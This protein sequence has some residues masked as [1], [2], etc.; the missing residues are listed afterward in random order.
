MWGEKRCDTQTAKEVVQDNLPLPT[1]AAQG[2]GLVVVTPSKGEMEFAKSANF[3]Y[4]V[5][6]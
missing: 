4:D 1:S 2:L 5:D 3:C 6:N